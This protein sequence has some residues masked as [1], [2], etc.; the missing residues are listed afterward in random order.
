M[1]GQ[2]RLSIIVRLLKF[3]VV[4]TMK[5]PSL[6]VAL[7]LPSPIIN[8]CGEYGLGLVTNYE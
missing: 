3:H 6:G 5:A 4:V 2:K 7:V 1:K 8:A